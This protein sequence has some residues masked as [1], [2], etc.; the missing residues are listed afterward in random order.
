[1]DKRGTVGPRGRSRSR[2]RSEDDRYATLVAGAVHSIADEMGVTESEVRNVLYRIVRAGRTQERRA[3]QARAQLGR[4]LG[5]SIAD[6]D[7]VAQATVQQA[8]RLAGLRTALLGD[9]AFSTTA[10][11]E[12]RGM[13]PSATRTWLSRQRKAHRLFTVN[14]DG[15]TLVPAFLLD[16]MMEPREGLRHAIG[17]LRGAGEDGWALWAWFATPSPWLGGQVPSVLAARDPERV[18]DAARRRAA[19]AA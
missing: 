15:E 9:G 5:P 6:L 11:A 18:A 19:S 3:P 1:M 8:R 12:A 4:A 17:A 7:P 10:I 13:S 2:E 16:E 14:H